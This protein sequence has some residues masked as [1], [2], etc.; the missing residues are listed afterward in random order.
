MSIFSRPKKNEKKEFKQRQIAGRLFII[1][2]NFVGGVAV[3]GYLGYL[4]DKRLGYEDRYMVVG[5]SLG[6]IW[7]VYEAIKMAYWISR[8]DDGGKDKDGDTESE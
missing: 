8:E 5:A 6:I 3:L 1:G 2:S 4:L 7:A